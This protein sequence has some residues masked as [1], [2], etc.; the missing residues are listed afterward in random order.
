[1]LAYVEKLE[2]LRNA[3]AQADAR[4]GEAPLDMREFKSSARRRLKAKR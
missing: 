4:G 3:V 2:G 1:V